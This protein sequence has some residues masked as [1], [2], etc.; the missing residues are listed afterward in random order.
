MAHPEPICPVCTR[1]WDRL[2]GY[3]DRCEG[4]DGAATAGDPRTAPRAAPP[5]ERRN[6][7]ALPGLL[8]DNFS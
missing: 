3:C 8:E 2:L 1:D 7:P 5:G 6:H 4:E